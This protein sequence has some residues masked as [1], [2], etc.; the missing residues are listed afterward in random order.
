MPLAL[1]KNDSVSAPTDKAFVSL[2]P[3]CVGG[4]TRRAA[5]EKDAGFF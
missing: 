5:V 1:A 3:G 2:G 4:K